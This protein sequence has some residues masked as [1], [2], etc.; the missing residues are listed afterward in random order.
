VLEP[1]GG[2][3]WAGI[4]RGIPIVV[5]DVHKFEGHIE[6]DGRANSEIVV[7]LRDPTGTIVGVL[8]VDSADFEAFDEVDEKKLQEV[9]AMIFA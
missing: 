6:C 7:P 4:D 9:L 1:H 8:D 2:V 5:P 3:C